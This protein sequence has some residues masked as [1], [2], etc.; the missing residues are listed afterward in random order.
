MSA[1]DVQSPV[2]VVQSFVML[3]KFRRVMLPVSV[4]SE[5]RVVPM[6]ISAF[7]LFGCVRMT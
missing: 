4:F 1:C 6:V 7:A 3:M 5:R 2:S